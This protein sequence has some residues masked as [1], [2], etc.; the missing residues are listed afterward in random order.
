MSL[1]SIIQDAADRI[2]LPEVSNVIGNTA[3]TERALLGAFIAEGKDLL[4]EDP[5]WSTLINE[6]TF[7]TSDG[8]EEYAL[9][10]DYQRMLTNTCWDRAQF[11]QV[12]G[13]LTPQQWQVIRSGLY[14]TARLSAN[15]RIKQAT[16]KISK[17]FY[18]DPIPG[19][20]RQ[21]V[22]EYQS[23]WWVY[24]TGNGTQRK[25]RPDL[26]TDETI[27]D[28]E[29]MTRGVIWRFLEMRNLPFGT[30]IA[31]YRTYRNRAIAQD[32]SPPS[33]TIHEQPWRLPIGNV[34]D[35]GF[36]IT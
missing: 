6:H 15:F 14:Q 17:A 27:F 24:G 30:H 16:D 12:R 18:L 22:F 4:Q 2:G 29:L 1:L 32:R 26:D 31:D 11:W 23:K 25:P 7:N 13:G 10:D 8:V 28:E 34:P 33:L 9:P 5:A 20:V 36:G 21:L 19:G 35:T 3:G